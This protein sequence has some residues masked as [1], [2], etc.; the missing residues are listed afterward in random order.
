MLEN[1]VTYR[2]RILKSRSPQLL[3]MLLD[4]AVAETIVIFGTAKVK[5]ETAY[6]VSPKGPVCSIDGGTECGEHLAKL[7]TGFLLKKFGEQGF[8]VERLAKRGRP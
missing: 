2:F 6:K 8:R 1:G 4:L 7:F 5:L 3:A